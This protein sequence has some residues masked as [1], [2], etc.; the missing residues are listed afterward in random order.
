MGSLASIV[1]TKGSKENLAD[2]V[3]IPVLHVDSKTGIPS[4]DNIA[5]FE[6]AYREEKSTIEVALSRGLLPNPE[7]P[8]TEKA[9]VD[10]AAVAYRERKISIAEYTTR[11]F[12]PFDAG[13]VEA[14]DAYCEK[15]KKKYKALEK[16][17]MKKRLLGA[18]AYT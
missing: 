18:L 15:L 13:D 5:S 9:K 10:A 14:L 8:I 17:D 2:I 3:P 11:R 16:E 4:A 7:R 1:V 6:A 12:E